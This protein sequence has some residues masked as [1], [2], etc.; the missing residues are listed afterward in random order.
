MR[1]K[2]K[3]ELTREKKEEMVSKIKTYFL[4]EREEELG[5]LAAGL[6]LN[7]IVEELAQE[8]YNQGI[9]DSY[10]YMNERIEELLLIQKF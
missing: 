8:F 3:I 4:N 6:I 10:K 9:Y 2:D 1:N 5:D 7:F